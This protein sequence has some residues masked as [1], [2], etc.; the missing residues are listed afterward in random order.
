MSS[1]RRKKKNSRTQG[2]HIKKETRPLQE[3]SQP[4]EKEENTEQVE[5]DVP[6]GDLEDDEIDSGLSERNEA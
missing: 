2:S 4:F 5:L 3:D 1:K 6:G